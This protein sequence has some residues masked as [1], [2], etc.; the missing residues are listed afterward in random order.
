MKVRQPSMPEDNLRDGS[1][2]VLLL[3]GSDWNVAFCILRS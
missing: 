3:I 2:V 1:G